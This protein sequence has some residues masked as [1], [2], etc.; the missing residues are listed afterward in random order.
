MLI[1][2]LQRFFYQSSSDRETFNIE[3]SKYTK[4]S[5]TKTFLGKAFMFRRLISRKKKGLMCPKL[6]QFGVLSYKEAIQLKCYCITSRKNC[7]A[8]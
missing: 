1:S 4:L 7:D 5:K 2:F 8:F 3:K 6:K